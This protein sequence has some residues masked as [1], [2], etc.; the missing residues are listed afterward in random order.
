VG[1]PAPHA[2]IT[3]ASFGDEA[4]DMGIPLE[5]SAKSM[6]YADKTRSELFSF[7]IFMKHTEYHTAN[8]RKQTSKES[9]VLQEKRTQLLSNGKD[10]MP[11]C[12]VDNLKRHGRSPVDG[13]FV[14]TGGTETAMA[15]E[16]HKL[17]STTF[18]TTIHGTA[19]SRITTVNHFINII[20][21]RLT[22]MQYVQHFFIMI[23]KNIL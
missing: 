21:D 9:T 10:A 16:W 20:Y 4:M 2:T 22:R 13:I 12:T 19:I 14:S 1:F 8:R 5:V 17:K 7:I 3:Q 6:K 11:M 18:R 23:F 15:A